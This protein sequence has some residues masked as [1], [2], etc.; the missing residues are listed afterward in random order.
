MNWAELSQRNPSPKMQS[1]RGRTGFRSTHSPVATVGRQ[2]GNVGQRA[3]QAAW[4]RSHPKVDQDQ[5]RFTSEV[6]PKLATVTLTTI[7]E[8]IG[9]STSTASKVRAGRRVPHPRHWAALEQLVR[10]EPKPA[11]PPRAD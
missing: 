10:M 2:Q 7:A 8:A 11:L 4:E 9:V 5:E 1:S 6:L 3:Q